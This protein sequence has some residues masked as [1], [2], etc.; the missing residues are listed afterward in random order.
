MAAQKNTC[1][2]WMRVVGN[3]DVLQ[4]GKK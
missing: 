2:A 4:S 1:G 3:E